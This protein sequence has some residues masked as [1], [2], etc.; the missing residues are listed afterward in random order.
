VLLFLLCVA[1]S[2]AQRLPEDVA[3][4]LRLVFLAGHPLEERDFDV[5][6]SAG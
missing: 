5:V 6:Y 1:V 4:I 3:P 2:Y